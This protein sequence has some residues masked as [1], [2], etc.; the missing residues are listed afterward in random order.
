MF[1]AVIFD[2][3]GLLLDTERL[4][5]ESGLEALVGLGHD[6]DR[7][8]MLS[9]VGIDAQEGHRRLTAHLG[10]DWAF[11]PFDAAWN[12]AYRKR[13]SGG[14][15]VKPGVETLLL[16]LD[17][18]RIPRAV[19]TNSRTAAAEGK[20]HEA[21]LRGWFGHVA[22]VDSVPKPKPAPDV[23]L[24]A[25]RAIGARPERCLAFEDS[26]TGVRAALA[27]GMTVVQVPDLLPSSENR[28]HHTAES[29]LEGARAC[30]LIP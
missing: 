5:L 2:M 16:H 26:D 8:F 3:D 13:L 25:A 12:T 22:G 7:A 17:D 14:I 9:L 21:G 6:V 15:P 18:A 29:L 30:G 4:A 11:G 20:L 28:A 19:A 23:Y 24:S 10:E 27:A 1:D